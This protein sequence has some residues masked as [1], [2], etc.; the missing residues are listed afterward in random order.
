VDFTE[1][2]RASTFKV[3]FRRDRHW[4]SGKGIK[5]KKVLR[6]DAKARLKHDE[7]AKS[8]GAKGLAFIKVEKGVDGAYRRMENRPS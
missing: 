2:F 3:F 8:F 7:Y 6:C 4:R 1:D 5:C